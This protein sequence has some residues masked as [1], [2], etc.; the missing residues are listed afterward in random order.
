LRRLRVREAALSTLWQRPAARIVPW[1]P[2]P[3][4]G[5]TEPSAPATTWRRD[6]ARVDRPP[7][8]AAGAAFPGSLEAPAGEG[9]PPRH[10]GSELEDR[11]RAG[12]H[13]SFAVPESR[14]DALAGD[15]PPVGRLTPG[16]V[17]T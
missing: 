10:R 17:A 9:L 1:T 5:P 16:P 8:P 12:V 11:A 2:L 6:R 13:R 3:K 14:A 7:P 4:I 15:A